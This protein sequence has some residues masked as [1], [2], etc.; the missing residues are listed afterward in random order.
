MEDL[1]KIGN[2]VIEL[3]NLKN[4][5]A[6]RITRLEVVAIDGEH[7]EKCDAIRTDNN[8]FIKGYKAR[9]ESAIE[10]YTRPLRESLQPILDALNPL[11]IANKEFA[12]KILESKKIAFKNEVKAMWQEFALA[13]DGDV[14]PFEKVYNEKWY[15]KSKITWMKLLA[16][17]IQK[18]NRKLNAQHFTIRLECDYNTLAEVESYLI[19]KQLNYKVEMED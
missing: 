13:G 7:P 15:G 19:D 9:I 16:E 10:E 5:V 3:D 6:A 12:D 17:A 14:P 8:N 1:I 18:E 11:E 2:D 4:V